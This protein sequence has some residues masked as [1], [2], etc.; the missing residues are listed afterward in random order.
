[1]AEAAEAAT[2]KVCHTCGVEK[3]IDQFR[4]FRGPRRIVLD[5]ADCRNRGR[6][7]RAASNARVSAAAAVTRGQGPA[8]APRQNLTHTV[9]AQ[10][11]HEGGRIATDTPEM[12]A[13]RSE[14][15]DIQR[16]HRL[17][18]RHGEEPSQ[19]PTM[20]NLL[21]QQQEIQDLAVDL[22][23]STQL[24]VPKR[25]ANQFENMEHSVEPVLSYR[26]TTL[27]VEWFVILP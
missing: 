8:F 15:S 16:R 7:Q 5:C 6:Q 20:S 3:E 19:T 21:R 9:L 18:R 26:Q 23:P 11:Y 17:E 13:A 2:C 22:P 27:T 10:R 4:S 25:L 1:M 14:V 24:R 12:A